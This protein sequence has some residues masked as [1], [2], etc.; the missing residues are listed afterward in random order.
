MVNLQCAEC[1]IRCEGK[2][3]VPA[4]KLCLYCGVVITL[5][6][7]N[8]RVRSE[9]PSAAPTSATLPYLPRRVRADQVC[10][11]QGVA[12][13]QELFRRVR[14]GYQNGSGRCAKENRPHQFLEQRLIPYIF[15]RAL[16]LQSFNG[17]HGVSKLVLDGCHVLHPLAKPICHFI[18]SD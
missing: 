12:R 2:R 17:L 3:K 9:S 16:L 1:K 4:A 5:I 11:S 13:T 10:L 6:L 8:R 15:L 14:Y 18:S 7:S